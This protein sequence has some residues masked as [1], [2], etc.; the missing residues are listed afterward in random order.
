MSINHRFKEE[1]TNSPLSARKIG[2]LAEIADRTLYD[3]FKD[4]HDFRISM[5]EKVNDV[6]PIDINYIITGVRKSAES[7]KSIS[8]NETSVQ[9]DG[10]SEDLN[11]SAKPVSH[12]NTG[13]AA[14]PGSIYDSEYTKVPF[15]N[16]YAHAGSGR[17]IEDRE[18]IQF[19]FRSYFIKNTLKSSSKDLFLIKVAGDSMEP[20]LYENDTI[21]I[22]RSRRSVARDAIYLVRL[23][24]NYRIKRVQKIANN[25]YRL[26]SDNQIYPP[27][28]I[29]TGPDCEIIGEVTWI[30][31][32][33]NPL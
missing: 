9:P 25:Q 28:D 24:D 7:V 32:T 31:R 20:T 29:S 30:G 15:Y 23:D 18:P 33:L 26:I 19:S 27:V 4:G 21:L 13:S 22:D 10:Q 17:L 12:S 8:H 1:V 2:Q 3:A 14:E 16:V 11:R 6:T 5:L